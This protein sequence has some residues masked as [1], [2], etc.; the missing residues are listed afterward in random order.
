MKSQKFMNVADRKIVR[1]DFEIDGERI[2]SSSVMMP[3]QYLF[4]FD[5]N[6]ISIYDLGQFNGKKGQLSDTI[7]YADITKVEIG[8][9]KKIVG[10]PY[11]RGAY[12]LDF[13]LRLT[14]GRNL[15]LD[16]TAVSSLEEIMDA[17]ESKD[18]EVIDIY[19]L[20]D[21]LASKKNT[22]ALYIYLDGNM[23][24]LAQ[25]KGRKL[26]KQDQLIETL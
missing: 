12:L 22:E 15:Y 10:V 2:K 25:A 21:I 3:P 24:S 20:K 16:S 19:E 14:D 13:I 9:I 6:E 8:M 18:I 17:F 1:V 23:E 26:L 4:A 7:S 5:K 11:P